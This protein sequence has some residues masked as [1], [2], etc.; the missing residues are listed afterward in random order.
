MPA[1]SARFD[2]MGPSDGLSRREREVAKLVADGLTNRQIGERLFIAERT[3]EGHV[4]QI[5]S[6]LGF[7]SRSQIAAWVARGGEPGVD[8]RDGVEREG[9]VPRPLSSL[10]GR[11]GEIRSTSDLVIHTPLVTI[12]GPGGIGKTRLSIEV[13][14]QVKDAFAGGAWFVELGALADSGPVAAAVSHALHLQS[15][16]ESAETQLARFLSSRK[17]LV[18]L[19][20]CE[21]VLEGC[22]HLVQSLLSR[23]A[24]LRV[25]ATSR[26]PLGV[27][28]EHVFRL[29]ALSVEAGHDQRS[30]AL[31]LLV[32]RSKEQG[33]VEPSEADLAHGLTVC[34]RLDGLP[35]AIELAAAQ[36]TALSFSELASQVEDRFRLLT[37][38]ARTIT[39]RH[40][41]LLATVDWSYQLLLPE[42]RVAF[43]RFSVFAG[44][45]DLGAAAAVLEREP[46]A[47]VAV[48]GSLIRKSMLGGRDQYGHRRYQML[49]TLRQFAM[50]RLDADAEGDR[51]RSLWA[52]H[53]LQL[54]RD[55]SPN[56][57]TAESDAWVR[58]L[59]E[60]RDNLNAVLQFLDLRRDPR[61]VQMV[62]ALGHYWIRGR[63]R[64]GYRWTERAIAVGRLEGDDRL[65]LDE[66][67]TWLTW[68]ANKMEAATEAANGWLAHS[69]KLADD[70]HIGRAL[71]VQ[72]VIRRDQGLH[73]DPEIW[74]AAETHLRRAG[75][76][77]AL[78]LLL[79]DIGFYAFLDGSR[80]GLELILEGLAFARQ[81]G[82]GWL[83]ALV[84]D[85]AAWAHVELGLRDQAASLW[86][87]GLAKIRSAPDR[88]LL[89]NYVEGFARV[90]RLEDDPELACKLLAAAAGLREE[91]GAQAPP[92][93]SE[94]LQTDFIAVRRQLGDEGFDAAW[95]TGFGMPADEAVELAIRRFHSI[96]TT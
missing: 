70:T 8:R 5:R 30:E 55:A 34:Q 27:T 26:E 73:V 16:T 24:G 32:Q 14:H 3:A 92:T 28:G 52:D 80:D 18:V 76:S 40:Q 22:A 9:D 47:T 58:R 13:A 6:K 17:A 48:V 60:E 41:T 10:I 37:S 12:T 7:T 72:A 35:L 69:R 43:R 87:E 79:N 23:S 85:S 45:F 77:W 91:V 57:R 90:A 68:Q 63:L 51:A 38:P 59:D 93:W 61:F 49:E 88:W 1:P 25:L 33:A 66:A 42:D 53:Y 94:Y 82:D 78:A 20:N 81:A 39:A 84:L 21:H 95:A 50:E 11:A 65:N 89:P 31:E 36:S 56:V 44:D 96:S 4:E 62:A 67:W 29:E 71:N 15:G 74:T 86:A 2:F 54:A 46:A 83:V 19:D 75:A 64:D